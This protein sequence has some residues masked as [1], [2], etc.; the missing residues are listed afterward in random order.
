MMLYATGNRKSKRHIAAP[1]FTG[2]AY[3]E[4]IQ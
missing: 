3:Y 1:V 4:L 2:A